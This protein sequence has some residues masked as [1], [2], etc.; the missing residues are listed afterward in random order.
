MGNECLRR[1]VPK[2]SG[3]KMHHSSRRHLLASNPLINILILFS[4]CVSSAFAAESTQ[5]LETITVTLG[6][7]A[8][9][10]IFDGTVEAVQQATVSAET[11]GR[12]QEIN[13]DVDDF[14]EAGSTLIRFTDVEQNTDLQR[15]EADLAGARAHLVEATEEFT[16][17]ENLKQRG[18]GSQRDLDR[19]VSAKKSAEATVSAA[20]SAVV[21]ARQQLQ[22]T[23]VR[24]PYSGIVTKRF[25]EVGETVSRGQP[26][27]SGLSLEKL[28]VIVDLPQQVAIEV[29]RDPRAVVL[30]EA[31]PVIPEKIIL[32]PVA[33]PV[34]KTFRVRL[35][36]PDGQFNLFPGMFVKAAFMVGEAERLLIPATAI[37][38]RSEVTAVYVYVDGEVRLRQIRVG[39]TFGDQVEV[40]AGLRDG[41]QIALDPVQAGI[42]AKSSRPSL[43]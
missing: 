26:L 19:A 5:P 39:A 33:D 11:S 38:Q 22:Y 27:M 30:T 23:V 21:S 3:K 28:R 41:E 9:E 32:F 13:F 35:E 29:R 18:L 1:H 6:T 15:A 34:T 40:L 14:V 24:A 10:R 7:T 2:D 20:E 37:V 25:V 4:A 12:I 8:V 42:Y 31:E 36:L 43:P 17:A 16:R